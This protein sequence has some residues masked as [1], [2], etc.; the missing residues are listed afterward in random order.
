MII[1]LSTWGPGVLECLGPLLQDHTE[2][3]GSA[4]SCRE[5]LSHTPKPHLSDTVAL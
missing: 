3:A 2:R 5:Y 1:R 4:S